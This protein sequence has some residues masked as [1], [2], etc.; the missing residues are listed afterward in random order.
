MQRYILQQ[1][2][3]VHYRCQGDH[4]Y[5][6]YF[7]VLIRNMNSRELHLPQFLSNNITRDEDKRIRN[8][9]LILQRIFIK[10]VSDRTYFQLTIIAWGI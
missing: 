1:L 5:P 4:K 9:F 10:R 8:I 3:R 7:H 2:L 6:D